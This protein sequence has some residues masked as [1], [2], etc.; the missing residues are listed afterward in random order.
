D[1]ESAVPARPR[2]SRWRGIGAVLAVFLLLILAVGFWQDWFDFSMHKEAEPG[3]VDRAAAE[4]QLDL[5]FSVKQDKIS[6]DLQQLQKGTTKLVQ[7][8]TTAAEL[9]SLEGR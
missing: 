3:A 4:E 2:R 1:S 6:Q 9:E 5:T 8:A 7:Q